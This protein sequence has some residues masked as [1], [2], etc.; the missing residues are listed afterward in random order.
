[1]PFLE[2]VRIAEVSF[3][4]AR[5]PFWPPTVTSEMAAP[6]GRLEGRATED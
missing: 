6:E 4:T 3:N 1:M 2:K 5:V